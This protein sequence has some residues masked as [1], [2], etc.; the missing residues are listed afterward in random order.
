MN[1]NMKLH[2]VPVTD[3]AGRRRLEMR[4]DQPATVVTGRFPVA[5]A[6]RVSRAA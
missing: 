4:W 6:A 5:G 1:T 3:G 2:W